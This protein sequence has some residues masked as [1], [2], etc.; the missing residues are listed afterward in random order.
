MTTQAM[1]TRL[2]R[3]TVEIRPAE[4]RFLYLTTAFADDRNPRPIG[5]K[6]FNS[7]F[8]H[9]KWLIGE[10]EAVEAF[11]ARIEADLSDAPCHPNIHILVYE[12]GDQEV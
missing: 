1:R 10:D 11:Q 7:D 3:L 9:M 8:A 2:D 12:Y 4:P 6:L 5:A